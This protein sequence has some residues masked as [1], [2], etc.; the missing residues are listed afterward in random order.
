MSEEYRYLFI[1]RQ[2]FNEVPAV[3]SFYELQ[4]PAGLTSDHAKVMTKLNEGFCK[5]EISQDTS[6]LNGMQLRLRFNQDMF[7]KVCMVR[8]A[9]PIDADDLQSVI[10]IKFKR[11]LLANFLKDSS[12]KM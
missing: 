8:T 4:V 2:E 11:G 12:L 5:N 3:D 10:N 9:T 1:V 7:Q 6:A